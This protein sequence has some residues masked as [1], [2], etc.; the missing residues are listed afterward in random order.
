M[1]GDVGS[2]L[3]GNIA[4]N[5]LASAAGYLVGGSSGAAIASNIELYNAQNN[6]NPKKTT[7][8]SSSSSQNPVAQWLQ[9]NLPSW[10]IDPLDSANK[11]LDNL[12]NQVAAAIPRQQP[13]AD[14]NPV[15]QANDGGPS[16]PSAP[17]VVTQGFA[18]LAAAVACAEAGIACAP[19]LIV[20][21]A[22]ILSNGG[23]GNSTNSASDNNKQGGSSGI[24]TNTASGN[25]TSVNEAMS[26]QAQAYQTQITG[27]TGQ[28]YVVNGVKFD[29]VSAN[30]TLLD[31]R[32][33]GYANFVASNGEF[34]PWFN[35]QYSLIDQAERQV[36]AAQGQPIQ[37]SVAEP[38]AATAIQNLLKS[39]GVKG[40]SVI[41]QS[42]K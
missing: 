8:P 12:G 7:S 13:P 29:G 5:V 22:P 23:S 38:S 28:A 32:G 37:W 24:P 33:P 17:A 40:I 41:Y 14:P 4:S 19:P 35:G 6:T 39:Q 20:P 34:Q 10:L 27:V 1:G 26:A 21:G 42:P 15:M 2:Q 30:G 25:W 9:D 16:N 11:K 36:A 31:V 18:A 3:I